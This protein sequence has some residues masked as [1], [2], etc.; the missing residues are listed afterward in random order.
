VSQ[1]EIPARVKDVNEKALAGALKEA[2]GIYQSAL[3]KKK[4]QKTRSRKKDE[5]DFRGPG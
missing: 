1:R 2:M 3:K 4:T 5:P